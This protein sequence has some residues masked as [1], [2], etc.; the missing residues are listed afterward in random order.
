MLDSK[1]DSDDVVDQ[2]VAFGI[3][4][5]VGDGDGGGDGDGL[6]DG[7]GVGEGEGEIIV[8]PNNPLTG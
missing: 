5:D 3:G 6:G 7:N 2:V 1:R 8:E 4:V